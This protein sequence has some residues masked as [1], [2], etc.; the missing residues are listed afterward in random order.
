MWDGLVLLLLLA[1]LLEVVFGLLCAALL[2]APL[3]SP[4]LMGAMTA[5]AAI[6]AQA[7][8]GVKQ[9]CC[10]CRGGVVEWAAEREGIVGEVVRRDCVHQGR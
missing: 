8:L 6:W 4:T 3:L 5:T 2:P 9:R 1:L 7:V 10:R